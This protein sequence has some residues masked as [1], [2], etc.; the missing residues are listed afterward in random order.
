MPMPKGN[1]R[2]HGG[3]GDGV[4][5]A[6]VPGAEDGDARSPAIDDGAVAGERS[7]SVVDVGGA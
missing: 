2:T 7:L 5:G 3:S 6:V 1:L 4:G